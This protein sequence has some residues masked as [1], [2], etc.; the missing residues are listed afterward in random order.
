MNI[1]ETLDD[2][3]VGRCNVDDILTMNVMKKNGEWF[4]SDNRRVW[5]FR[6]AEEIGVLY[7][8]V[9]LFPEEASLLFK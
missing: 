2:L 9:K 3:L 1:G 7:L 5:V 6:T 8:L 4:T